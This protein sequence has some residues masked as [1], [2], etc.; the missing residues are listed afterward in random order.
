MYNPMM[1]SLNK[2]MRKEMMSMMEQLWATLG[3]KMLKKPYQTSLFEI[4]Q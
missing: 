2:Q 1:M 4:K 3:R